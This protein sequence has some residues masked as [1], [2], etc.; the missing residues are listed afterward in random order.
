M[1]TAAPDQKLPMN[2]DGL[3]YQTQKQKLIQI[4]YFKLIQTQIYLFL[5]EWEQPT[6]K[7]IIHINFTTLELGTLT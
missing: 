5:N 7:N 2:M 4:Y 6:E 1:R 3:N